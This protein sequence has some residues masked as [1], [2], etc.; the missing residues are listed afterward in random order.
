MAFVYF[1]QTVAEI[2]DGIQALSN[3]MVLLETLPQAFREGMIQDLEKEFAKTAIPI[4]LHKEEPVG[5][6]AEDKANNFVTTT[7]Q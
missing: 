7:L 3:M 6:V 2:K 4:R 1:H 5:D